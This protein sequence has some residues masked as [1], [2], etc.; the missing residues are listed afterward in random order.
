MVFFIL[1]FIGEV[2]IYIYHHSVCPLGIG[3]KCKFPSELGLPQ[4]LSPKRVC[5]PSPGPK[6]GGGGD[7]SPAAKG[8]G[9]FQFRRLEKK[10]STLATLWVGQ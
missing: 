1:S 10:L 5:P 3:C 6:G 2:L 8:V 7:Y 4:P 9:E